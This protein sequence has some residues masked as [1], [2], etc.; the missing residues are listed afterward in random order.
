VTFVRPVLFSIFGISVYIY[1]LMISCALGTTA[2][3]MDLE[4]K[5]LGLSQLDAVVVIICFL[6]GFY[7]GSKTQVF[8][9]AYLNGTSLPSAWL[10]HSHSFMGSALGGV[11]TSTVYGCYVF[12]KPVHFLD[13]LVPHV[14]LGHAIG[15]LGC[16]FSGDGCYGTAASPDLPWAMSFPNGLVPV[17]TPVHPAPLYEFFLSGFIFVFVCKTMRV[18][19][20]GDGRTLPAGRRSA[21]TI[22]LYGIERTI[23]EPFRRHSQVEIVLGL[24]EYHVMVCMFMFIAG[25]VSYLGHRV[26]PWPLK[27]ESQRTDSQRAESQRAES[28]RA[29]KDR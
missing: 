21:A 20:F 22:I 3:L 1:G 13:I 15:K 19:A 11:M 14:M 29:K 7:L 28:K 23:I 12:C 27:A 2:F 18:P 10:K 16:F 6:P 25:I 5:R 8:A 17:K 4:H 24:S 26:E 9:S